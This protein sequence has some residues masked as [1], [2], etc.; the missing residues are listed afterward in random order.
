MTTHF[1]SRGQ[2]QQSLVKIDCHSF[3]LCACDDGSF[4]IDLGGGKNQIAKG[5]LR[6]SCSML[7]PTIKFLL[8]SSLY[9]HGHTHTQIS[10]VG[11]R[12]IHSLILDMQGHRDDD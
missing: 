11:P 6:E 1:G 5:T 12:T 2:L 8:F 4:F 7:R 9:A 10:I 3:F